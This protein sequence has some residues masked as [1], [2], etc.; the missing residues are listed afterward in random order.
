LEQ[1]GHQPAESGGG[2]AAAVWALP[3]PTL[4][5]AVDFS[6][7]DVFVGDYN[8]RGN[9]YAVACRATP[10]D[11]PA[12]LDTLVAPLSVG[13]PLPTLPLWLESD[14]AEP[15]D[16]ERSYEATFIELRVP[17]VSQ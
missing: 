3:T 2:V 16:L 4:S 12:R 10:A 17:L 15:L 14:L 13:S 11:Q 5:V 1:S 6:H 8:S 7:L 9:L